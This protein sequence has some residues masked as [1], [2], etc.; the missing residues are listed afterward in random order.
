MLRTA[1]ARPRLPPSR[2]PPRIHARM[3]PCTP[4]NAAHLRIILVLLHPPHHPLPR[5][6]LR[7]RALIGAATDVAIGGIGGLVREGEGDDGGDLV[8]EQER[9]TL[10]RFQDTRI[11]I[12]IAPLALRISSHQHRILGLLPSCAACLRRYAFRRIQTTHRALSPA[13]CARTTAAAFLP[14]PSSSFFL[15]LSAH[16]QYDPKPGHLHIA[17]CFL[18]SRGR[19]RGMRNAEE[20][21]GE[22]GLGERE[23]GRAEQCA[24]HASCSVWILLERM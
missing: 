21:D 11:H 18:I 15:D 24:A 4:P 5:R 10:L 19:T 8:N 9:D 3:S 14:H 1:T 6:C 12:P 23:N 20:G 7:A 22:E 16:L 13:W 17:A 2:W